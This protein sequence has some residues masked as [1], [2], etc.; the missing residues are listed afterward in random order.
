[1]LRSRR[2]FMTTSVLRVSRSPVGSSSSK[3]EGLFEIALDMVTLCCSPPES[4]LGKWSSLSPRP[5]SLS[6][7]TALSLIFSLLS[8]PLSCMGSSTFS[9]AVREP[10]KLKVWNTKPSLLSRMEASSWSLVEYLIL[11]PQ[12]Y[13]SPLEGLSMVPMMLRRVVLP[14]PEV[15]RMQMSSP[16]LIERFT[17]LKAGTPSS[18]SK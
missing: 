12:M 6:K 4:W 9:R 8:L 7:L 16:S 18:P 11:R 3:I 5:T 10:I 2:I 15:P 13:T 14:P 1:M 17:P